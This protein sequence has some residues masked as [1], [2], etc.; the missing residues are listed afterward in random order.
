[1]IAIAES[2]STKCEW[3]ILN[4][5]GKVVQNFRTQGF[6]PDFHSSE[7]VY[8]TLEIC[9]DLLT[10]KNN[11]N[12]V[13]FYGA[14]CSSSVL[15]E[16]IKSGLEKVFSNAEITVDHDLL[17][18]ACSLYQDEPIICGILGTGSNSCFFDGHKVYEEIPAL[19]FVIGDEGGGG[20][21]GKQLLADYFYRMLPEEIQTDF[22][23]QF[24][25]TWAEA[26]KHIYGDI[27]ANVYCASFMPFIAKYKETEYVKKMIHTGMA[28]FINAHVKCFDDYNTK[29]VGFVGSIAYIFQDIIKEELEKQGYELS[30]IIKSPIQELVEYHRRTNFKMVDKQKSDAILNGIHVNNETK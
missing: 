4:E 19:G 10:L 9:D 16:I 7:Y 25:L 15:N 23:E 24:N 12:K 8:N 22:R 18:A 2:G 29:K 6:N 26:R 3:V 28:K 27:H 20:Y 13:F 11:I 30:H 5:E 1:M 21:F 14:G 17:A